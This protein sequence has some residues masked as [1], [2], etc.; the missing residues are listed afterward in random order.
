MCACVCERETEERE[1]KNY[2]K[3][4]ESNLSAKLKNTSGL[5]GKSFTQ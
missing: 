2:N 5:L 3:F 1:V 4:Q